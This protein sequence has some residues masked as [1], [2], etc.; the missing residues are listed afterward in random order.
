MLAPHECSVAVCERHTQACRGGYRDE[1]LYLYV[2]YKNGE[3]IGE[4]MFSLWK[5]A[6]QKI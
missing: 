2:E 6:E 3:D 5:I 4:S 1:V